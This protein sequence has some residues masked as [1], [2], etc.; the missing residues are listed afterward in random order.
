MM[1]VHVISIV[2][3]CHSVKFCEL[4]ARAFRSQ[5]YHH[6]SKAS[7]FIKQPKMCYIVHT[8]HNH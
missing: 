6:T 2:V 3:C 7:Y 5:Q 4:A 8:L 1:A